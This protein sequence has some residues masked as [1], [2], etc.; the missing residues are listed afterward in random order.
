[1]EKSKTD[2][3]E[4]KV[5][6]NYLVISIIWVLTANIL[7]NSFL[8]THQLKVLLNIGISL[9]LIFATSLILLKQL[10][11]I[12]VTDAAAKLKHYELQQKITVLLENISDAFVSLDSNWRYTYMN[13]KA[14][15]IFNRNPKDMVGKHIWTEFPEGIDQPFYNNYYK[16]IKEQLFIQMEEYYPPYDKWFENR[17]YP[18][19]EGLAI[20]F[21]DITERKK[22]ESFNAFQTNILEMISRPIG[23]HKIL[24]EIVIGIEK[25]MSGTIATILLLDKDGKHVHYGAA[26]NIP[27]DYN[28]AI[29]AAQIGEKAGSCGTAMYLKKTIIVS[30]IETDPLWDDYR[31]LALKHNLRACWSTP[32]INSN[33]K[34]LGSFALYYNK[35][36]TP[37][38]KD[39]NII[40]RIA[41]I[42]SIAIEHRYKETSL[43]E[44][45]QYNRFLFDASVIG[46][47]LCGMDG[48]LIDVNKA[49]ANILGYS[50]S[51]VLKLSYWDITPKKYFA[52]EQK[53]LEMLEQKGAYGP[54]EKEYI[55]KEGGLI[56]VRLYGKVIEQKKE[57]LIWSSVEDI[58]NE[59]LSEKTLRESENKFSKVFHNSPD[60]IVITRV[61]DGVILDA[62]NNF[63][64]LTGYQ[65]F[66]V[67]GR[68]TIE[69]NLWV[70]IEDSNRFI[71]ILREKKHT[72]EFETLFRTKSGEIRNFIISGEFIELSG[73]EFI[74]GILHD[75]T[76]RK[77][78]EEELKNY[79]E[80]LEEL[81]KQRT[82]ELEIEKLRA[83]SADKLKSAFLATMSHELRTPL[84]S[85][86]GFS[87]I[88]AQEHPGKLNSEQKKQ[89]GMV[90]AS[91]RH[92]LALINDIL[93]LS[94]I[95]AGQLK[96]SFET[97]NLL[98]II[99]KAVSANQPFAEKKNIQ[100]N[101]S[102]EEELNIVSDPLRVEQ[103]L[104][105]VI[106][107]AIK[108]TEH[109][110]V[111]ISCEN[112]FSE[113]VINVKDTGIGIEKEKLELLFKP[114]S[115]IDIGL[116]RKQEGTGLG[117]S[118]CKKLLTLL[119]GRIEV[120][121]EMGSGSV[122]KIILPLLKQKQD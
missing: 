60:S 4:V 92:L 5:I 69:L 27:E 24:E 8:N 6:I 116:T 113:I 20:F 78:S 114:F 64:E 58:T 49:F 109:G 16:A 17:I 12:T 117:L 28:N 89:L 30:D 25:E 18:S 80:H 11:N 120:E 10:R 53:Q 33:G 56:P 39:L 2:L 19:K 107:N 1:M 119:N 13:K 42:A 22:N 35:P 73:E 86:I 103:I 23:L 110:Y 65:A 97:F 115:Q 95:E 41:S 81:V 98:A 85:I 46:L 102:N 77:K 91:A 105:N 87:G 21:Y 99:R 3:K 88:L 37:N 50:I 15:E 108:F 61:S 57:K 100:I 83:E 26:P 9:L 45:N 48:R 32:I 94:K 38:E 84:N 72:Q 36:S 44:S 76:E 54:Y 112:N 29:E 79:K 59:R 71:K 70:R 82:A 52:Q 111:K 104:L 14:G 90:Q 47:A 74:I 34:V 106:N 101:I 118:I 40:S 66:E 62:N 51:E 67:I 68:S 43:I 55:N 93:D 75:I 63:F 121:S 7:I 96:V 122:F 31:V